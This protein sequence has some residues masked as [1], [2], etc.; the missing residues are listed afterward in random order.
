MF[1]AGHDFVSDLLPAPRD[2]S[3]DGPEFPLVDGSIEIGVGPLSSAWQLLG[4]NYIPAEGYILRLRP[5]HPQV[6]IAASDESGVHYA[7]Q[8]LAQLGPAPRA[9]TITDSPTLPWRGT[10][11]GFYGEPWTH[12]QRLD[13][14]RFAGSIKLNTYVYAPKDDPYHRER[15]RDLY[16]AGLLAELVELDQAARANAVRFVYALHPAGTMRFTD[17]SDVSG[18]FAKASQ[19]L[20]AGIRS[21]ALLFDDVPL[22][23]TDPGDQAAFGSDTRAVGAAHGATCARFAEFLRSRGISEPLIMVPT[24]YAGLKASPYREGLEATLD[25]DAI[26]WWTGSDIVVGT[27]SRDDID[28]AAASHRRKLLL[29]DN[30]PVNDFDRNRLFLGPLQGRTTDVMDAPFLGITANPMVD[31]EPSKF[32]LAA[33]ADWA[34]NTAAYEPDS[35]A[36]RC[37]RLL[38]AERVAPL[39]SALS[40][41]PPSAPQDPRLSGFIARALNGNSEDLRRELAALGDVDT[42]VA[43]SLG[44]TRAAAAA[45]AMSRAGLAAIDGSAEEAL[46]ALA[47]AEAHDTNVLRGVI[48]PFVR[49]VLAR[50]GV[51]APPPRDAVA[52]PVSDH[53][54]DASTL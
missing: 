25:P 33:V 49:E 2:V 17:E 32:G 45:V 19:L 41:W 14:L 13:H 30:F 31:Y 54:P 22:S 36:R 11:E 53:E 16:P 34:W 12:A 28:R 10:I 35:A 7:K 21:I 37:L 9:M 27:I 47:E 48:P 18:L 50:S 1:A 24:D 3:I 40:S 4:A 43:A 26:V 42:D 15:W 44:L 8:T 23:L 51:D 46:T 6:L 38:G 52:R 39:V 29:W 20:D 5:G